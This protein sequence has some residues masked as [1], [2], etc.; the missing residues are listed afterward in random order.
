MEKKIKFSIICPIYN[1]EKFLKECIDSVIRQTYSNWELIL[2]DDGSFDKSPDICASYVKQFSK[3]IKY[4]YKENGGVSSARNFGLEKICGNYILF[5]DSDDLISKDCL[6]YYFYLLSKSNYD[7]IWCSFTDKQELLGEDAKEGRVV[8]VDDCLN[9]FK[10]LG[11]SSVCGKC[12][13]S[14]LLIHK[15]DE[16]YEYGEDS[17]FFIEFLLNNAAKIYLSYKK[18][19]FYR[20]VCTS[21]THSNSINMCLQYFEI[22]RKIVSLYRKKEKSNKLIKSVL[23]TEFEA[24]V[25]L[26]YFLSKNSVRIPLNVKDELFRSLKFRI[27]YFFCIRIPIV[28]KAKILLLSFCRL[29]KEN[30]IINE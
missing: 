29:R 18:I 4:F 15:F 13:N 3:K 23:C 14:K 5:I 10:K 28:K 17:L 22:R 24:A 9:R 19:Y 2:I 8:S 30:V 6:E 7:L 12:F 25:C 1:S 11:S 27:N 21:A 20:N 26:K 16:Q